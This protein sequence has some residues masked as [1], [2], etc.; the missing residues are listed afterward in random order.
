[1]E[2][3]ARPLEPAPAAAAVDEVRAAVRAT[4]A[5]GSD[6]PGASREEAPEAES[7]AE[8]GEEWHQR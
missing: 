8:A 4:L 6:R 3:D 7:W 5:T 1:V 2:P